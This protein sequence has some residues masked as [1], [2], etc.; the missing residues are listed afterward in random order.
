MKIRGFAMGIA[1]FVL[2]MAN[3]A[4]SQL[5]LTINRAAGSTWTF[6]I[7][8]A[9]GILSLI[10]VARWVPETKGHSLEDLESG[11]RQRYSATP[12]ATSRAR[13]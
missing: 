8:L 7:F 13:S 9:L 12:A 3:F 11:F 4:I 10:F 2:W 1:V 5:F 6:L